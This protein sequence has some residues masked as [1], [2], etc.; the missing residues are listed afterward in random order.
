MAKKSGF[1]GSV[2]LPLIRALPGRQP[3]LVIKLKIAFRE[4]GYE[5]LVWG[6]APF[7]PVP[8]SSRIPSQR[9][10]TGDLKKSHYG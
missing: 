5:R 8:A 4:S 9:N 2:S 1:S 7:F 10:K 3:S 6:V